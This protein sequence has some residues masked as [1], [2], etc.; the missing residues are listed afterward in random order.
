MILLIMAMTN[1]LYLP[2]L[3]YA[4]KKGQFTKQN[5]RAIKMAWE[6]G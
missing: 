4:T 1:H 5:I 2:I 3:E 6:F